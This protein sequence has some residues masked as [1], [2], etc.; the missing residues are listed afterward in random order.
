MH[1]NCV[2]VEVGSLFIA[3]V[4][5]GNSV[6]SVGLKFSNILPPLPKG[7]PTRVLQDPLAS[8]FPVQA[9][10]VTVSLLPGCWESHPPVCQQVLYLLSRP[11]SFLFSYVFR[12]RVSSCNHPGCSG[13]PG[14]HSVGLKLGDLSVSPS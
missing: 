14:T 13:R 9:C 6:A 8:A 3:K 4:A 10:T 1:L 5:L 2:V 11:S 12:D 7:W